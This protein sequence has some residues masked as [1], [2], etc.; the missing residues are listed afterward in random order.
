MLE[1]GEIVKLN[2]NKEYIVINAIYLNN[3][4]YVFLISNFKPLVT[5]VAIEKLNGDNIIL[6]EIKENS[7]LDYVLTQFALKKE[8]N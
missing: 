6:E 7:L 8:N 5:I 1:A 2:N 3:L 4:R